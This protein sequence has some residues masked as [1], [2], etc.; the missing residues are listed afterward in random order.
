MF[1][2]G[3]LRDT[4]YDVTY[5]MHIILSSSNDV[6][7][8]PVAAIQVLSAR[9]ADEVNKTSDADAETPYANDL[10]KELVV[11][12]SSCE[13]TLQLDTPHHDAHWL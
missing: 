9:M 12:G 6:L 10:F 8:L 2:T 4:L 3:G 1:W 11:A 7:I 13:G 5:G